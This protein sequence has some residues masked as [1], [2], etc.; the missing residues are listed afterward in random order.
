MGDHPSIIFAAAMI[1][2]YGL[3]SKVADRS[4]ITAP[5]IFVATGIMVGPL[6]FNVFHMEPYGALVKIIT[7]VTLVLILFVDA[8][9]INL[10]HLIKDRATPIRLLL[11][12]LPLT[13]LTG[14]LVA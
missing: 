7:E 10:K 12:G 4:P 1:F 9:T 13:M 6:G 8:T 5:M 3:F 2:I 14:T 11:I